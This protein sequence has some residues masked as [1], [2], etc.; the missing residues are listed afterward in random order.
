MW[1][2]PKACCRDSPLPADQR[3][4]LGVLSG[5]GAP[6]RAQ[7][8]QLASLVVVTQ[9]SSLI[10]L[11]Q[12]VS[13][14]CGLATCTLPIPFAW[15][16]FI[17]PIVR[18]HC[19]QFSLRARRCKVLYSHLRL[20]RAGPRSS[21]ADS[22]RRLLP[23]PAFDK[24]VIP[25]QAGLRIARRPGLSFARPRRRRRCVPGSNRGEGTRTHASERG[26]RMM[27]VDPSPGLLRTSMLPLW[28]SAICRA[29]DSPNPNPSV[30]RASSAR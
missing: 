18:F 30:D 24:T 13:L 27:K 16:I 14:N 23:P 17:S 19:V 3:D 25:A 26:M 5:P 8:V 15:R 29:I 20:R 7:P 2:W 11:P 21:G 22:G 10:G 12:Y 6:A 9:S 28:S 4:A 1:C